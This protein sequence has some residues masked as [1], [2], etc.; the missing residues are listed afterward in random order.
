MAERLAGI[1]QAGFDGVELDAHDLAKFSGSISESVQL[2]RDS[3]LQV[4]AFKELRDFTG[5]VGHVLEYRM[6]LAKTNLSVMQKLG[7]DLLIV[8]PSA[9]NKTLHIS[10]LVAQLRALATLAMKKGI[11]V[12]YRPLPWSDHASDLVSAWQ[13]IEQAGNANLGLVVD[14]FQNLTELAISQV[15]QQIPV[16]KIFLLRVS[17]FKMSSL[18]IMEDKVEVDSHQRFLPGAGILTA[19]LASLL[20][21]GFCA[22]YSGP[23]VMSLN[24]ESYRR[25]GL[26]DTLQQASKSLALVRKYLG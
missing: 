13:L 1:Q 23:V 2:I 12:G 5:H 19:D 22:G 7:C 10:D 17:D 24:D 9:S 14:S 26:V 4:S 11:R 16:A 15:F 20:A 6:E 18:H 21:Q 8:N 3:G 25:N